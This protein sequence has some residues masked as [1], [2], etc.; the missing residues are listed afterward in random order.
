MII[1][2]LIYSFVFI[3]VTNFVFSQTNDFYDDAETVKLTSPQIEIIGEISNPRKVDLSILPIQSV[4]VK[5]TFLKDE[6]DE[7]VGA[8]RYDG[9]AL[10]DILNSMVLKKKNEA[11]FKPIIDL[12]VEIENAKGEKVVLSWGEIYYPNHRKEIIIATQVA[13]IVPSKTKDLWPLPTECKLV[14][15]QDL[16]TERNISNPVK[17]TIKSFSKS[18]PAN[19]GMNPMYSETISIYNNDKV[20][21]TISQ[22]PKLTVYN[23]PS[24]FYGRGTGI[25]STLPFK[26]VLL[27]EM[28]QGQFKIKKENLQNGF[29]AIVGKDGYRAVFTFSEIFNRNDQS[30]FLVINRNGD[31]SGGAFSVFPAS[32]FFSDRAI[33]SV[34][35][36]YFVK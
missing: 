32:D 30:E 23:F 6:N 35:E 9:Y 28:L 26:G 8:Y 29:F 18:I 24:I 3:C 4:I 16:V 17:I 27:K 19:K 10:Y 11:E 5:E 33:K 20:V 21:E 25:H 22:F 34:T 12:Y 15:A 2:F 13:R 1:R 7:F 36:I 31:N 14:V